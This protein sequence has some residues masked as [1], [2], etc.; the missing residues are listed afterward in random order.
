[1]LPKSN[2]MKLTNGL[3][4][5]L[6]LVDAINIAPSEVEGY[7]DVSIQTHRYLRSLEPSEQRLNHFALKL[8]FSFFNADP[9]QLQAEIQTAAKTTHDVGNVFLLLPSTNQEHKLFNV[10]NIVAI[11]EGTSANTFNVVTY[12]NRRM[13]F[14][15]DLTEG[16]NIF[17]VIDAIYKAYQDYLVDAGAEAQVSTSSIGDNQSVSEVR[18][19]K[20]STPS[21]AK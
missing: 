1:M 17:D 5:N 10:D 4:I 21:V 13:L 18:K 11:T 3:L 19:P 12:D 9:M 8:N 15:Q 20:S 7:T 14:I 16:E 6:A 2:L